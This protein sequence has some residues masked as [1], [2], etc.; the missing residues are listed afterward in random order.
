MSL[1]RLEQDLEPPFGYDFKECDTLNGPGFQLKDR[2]TGEGFLLTDFR[3]KEL[4]HAFHGLPDEIIRYLIA[5]TAENKKPQILDIGGGVNSQTARDI[6]KRYKEKVHVTNI[7]LVACPT[8]GATTASSIKGDLFEI[9][10]RDNSID[11][12]FSRSVFVSLGHEEHHDF[13]QARMDALIASLGGRISGR[14]LKWTR[15]GRVK[16][17]FDKGIVSQRETEALQEIFRVLKP[18][19]VALID[20]GYYWSQQDQKTLYASVPDGSQLSFGESGLFLNILDRIEMLLEKTFVPG[21]EKWH[22]GYPFLILEKV[23]E[24]AGLQGLLEKHRKYD[25][26]LVA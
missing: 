20:N 8:D 10:L 19:G 26:P 23:P 16:R 11:F 13:S 2:S 9:P 4:N 12:A 22:S 3:F 15:V 7:D 6:A 21:S 14:L 24:N 25:L 18:G 17:N 5:H 1:I